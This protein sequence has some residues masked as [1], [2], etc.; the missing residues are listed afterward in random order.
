MNAEMKDVKED[1][2]I[3]FRVDEYRSGSKSEFDGNVQF[4]REE[5][6]DVIYLSGYKSRNDFIPWSDILAKVDMSKP[7]VSL[8]SAPYEGHFQV[9]NA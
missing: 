6:V 4:V 3:I 5:G 8:E 9:F 2:V 7:R 1:D